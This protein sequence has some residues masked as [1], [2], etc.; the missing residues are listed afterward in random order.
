MS[1]IPTRIRTIPQ[2]DTAAG[3]EA[4]LVTFVTEQIDRMR[5]YVQF[6]AG[7]EPTFFEINQALLSYQDTQL[8]LLALHNTSKMDH[9][10]AKEEFDDWYADKYLLMR[11]RVNPISLSAQKWASQKEIELMVRKE[12]PTEFHKY[13][14]AVIE[15]EQQ[16][17]FMRRLVDSWAS[18]QFVLTQ[19]SKNIIAELGGLSVEGSL[20]TN[21]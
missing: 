15:A 1:D 18:Y 13:N 11:E 19:L 20:D 17:A 3:V 9:T 14:W 12:F 7:K 5:S 21:N 16:L 8:G 4:R 2:T 6:Q 10:R